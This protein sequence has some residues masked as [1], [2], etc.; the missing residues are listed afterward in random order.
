MFYEKAVPQGL[1]AG[2]FLAN[3]YF[4]DFDKWLAKKIGENL[5]RVLKVAKI[6]KK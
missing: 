2:G 3:I 6:P 5:V 4:L 1:V